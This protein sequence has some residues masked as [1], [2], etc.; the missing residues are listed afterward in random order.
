[1]FAVLDPGQGWRADPGQP[2]DHLLR[3]APSLADL[4]Y[5]LADRPRFLS[6]HTPN[7]TSAPDLADNA[8]RALRTTGYP[9]TV[10]TGDGTES[11]PSGVP[12]DRIMSPAAVQQVPYLWEAD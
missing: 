3:L 5:P 12:Y 1:V 7:G 2:G 9:V 4:P 10:I 6:V 8:H 11:Y